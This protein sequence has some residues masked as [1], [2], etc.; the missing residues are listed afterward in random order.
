MSL[1]YKLRHR[2]DIQKKT[3][4]IDSDTGA[5]TPTWVSILETPE[6]ASLTPTTGREFIASQAN[7]QE[8][9]TKIVIRHRPDIE[10]TMRVV[11]DGIPYVI[12]AILPDF[13]MRSYITLLCDNGVSDGE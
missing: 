5:R 7:Q 3:F 10:P 9:T 6:P 12:R 13:T 4:A 1:A 8:I 11:H 2:I